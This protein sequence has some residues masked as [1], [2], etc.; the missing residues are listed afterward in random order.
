MLITNGSFASCFPPASISPDIVRLFTARHAARPPRAAMFLS[1]ILATGS[2]GGGA[3]F[4]APLAFVAGAAWA[5]GTAFAGGAAFA[6]GATS[7]AMA[8]A[9]A[10][11]AR[12]HRIEMLR[13][14]VA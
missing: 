13:F 1:T 2:A 11:E 8:T 9:V 14:M 4:F 3:I 10:I 12:P 7:A 5:A 6:A